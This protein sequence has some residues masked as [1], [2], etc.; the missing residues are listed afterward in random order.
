MTKKFGQ[1]GVSGLNYTGRFINEDW[2]SKLNYPYA[3]KVYKEM[4]E[5]DSVVGA[6]LTLI[7]SEA[8]TAEWYVEP[9]SDE[10]KDIEVAKFVEECMDDMENSWTDFISEVLSMI[11]YGFSYHEIVYKIRGGKSNNGKYNSKHDDG[12]IGWR[13]MPIRSQTSMDGWEFSKEGDL[14]GMYQSAA[15]NY[16]SV[17]IPYEKA[18]LFRTDTSNNNPEG[19]SMLRKSYKAWTYKKNLEEIEAISIERDCTGLPVL[20]YPE[21]MDLYEEDNPEMAKALQSAY[22]LLDNVRRGCGNGLLLQ[23]GWKLELL[24]S[25]GTLTI[26]PNDV[27]VRYSTQIAQSMLSDIITLGYNKEGSFALAQVK[28]DLITGFIENMLEKVCNEL[29][30]HVI[31]KLI[32]YNN[33]PGVLGMPKI[34]FRTIKEKQPKDIAVVL[35][36]LGIDAKNAPQVIEPIFAMMGLPTEDIDDIKKQ[37]EEEKKQEQLNNNSNIGKPKSKSKGDSDAEFEGLD[38]AGTSSGAGEGNYGDMYNDAYGL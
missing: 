29:N 28:K 11:P 9:F 18:A 2:I 36:A 33:F 22:D 12:R 30:N 6:C 13:K 5:G 26:N 21:N 38:G 37:L 4:S 25:G 24:T 7:K 15:P 23:E 19:I 27:I 32:G 8:S 34:R 14:E 16:K 3:S 20:Q 17:L 31:P 35:K 10:E 1:V